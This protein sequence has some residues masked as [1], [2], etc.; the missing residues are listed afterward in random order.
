M[1]CEGPESGAT[2]DP[3]RHIAELMRNGRERVTVRESHTCAASE[4]FELDQRVVGRVL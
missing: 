2:N 4:A 1:P 3:A